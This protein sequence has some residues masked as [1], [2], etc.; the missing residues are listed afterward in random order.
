MSDSTHRVLVNDF[1]REIPN[2]S[3]K[4][5]DNSEKISSLNA[6]S[7]ISTYLRQK[8]S[9]SDPFNGLLECYCKKKKEVSWRQASA[10]PL[11]SLSPRFLLFLEF[12]PVCS[13]LVFSS[14]CYLLRPSQPT[15]RHQDFS[16][17]P[18]ATQR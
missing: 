10:V 7:N 13:A 6:S 5:Q 4:I 18:W 14:H 12:S 11:L 16:E 17:Y 2:K 8:I 1:S 3:N 9:L 15:L